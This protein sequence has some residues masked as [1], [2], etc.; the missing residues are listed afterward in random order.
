MTCFNAIFYATTIAQP[1]NEKATNYRPLQFAGA[2]DKV[3]LR[4]VREVRRGPPGPP[5]RGPPGRGPPGRGGPPPRGGGHGGHGGGGPPGR[6]P[7][8]RGPPGRGGPGGGRGGPPAMVDVLNP[9]LAQQLAIAQSAGGE[10]NPGHS[11]QGDFNPSAAKQQG[12]RRGPPAR[13]PP[14]RGPPPA[15]DYYSYDYPAPKPKPK[16]G[17]FG[18]K[19]AGAVL[20]SAGDT[21]EQP[22]DPNLEARLQR[23]AEALAEQEAIAARAE[24]EFRNSFIMPGLMLVVGLV[25]L[26]YVIRNKKKIDEKKA[27]E[28]AIEN[29]QVSSA[30]P[31]ETAELVADEE[32]DPPKSPEDAKKIEE[33]YKEQPLP[34][35][36]HATD[37]RPTV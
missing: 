1:K 24:Q 28:R 25:I 3:T 9:E 23:E 2:K 14:A 20:K 12:P 27:K 5:G 31:P 36:S 32:Q 11:T 15:Q 18:A 6:G 7:P 8:G 19:K 29:E 30:A 21:P 4:N 10:F 13:G 33:I 22:E 35:N 26:A 17:G 16:R 37:N 34:V